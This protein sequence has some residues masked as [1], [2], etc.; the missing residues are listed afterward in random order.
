M[1]QPCRANRQMWML[2]YFQGPPMLPYLSMIIYE[3]IIYSI[4]RMQYLASQQSK[5]IT[6]FSYI[7]SRSR[8]FQQVQNCIKPITGCRDNSSQRSG[9]KYRWSKKEIKQRG[10]Y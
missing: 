9:K 1:S 6:L 3:T 4:F 10:I 7:Y 5:S 8:A 2:Y